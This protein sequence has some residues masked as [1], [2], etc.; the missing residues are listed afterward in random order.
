MACIR[1][2]NHLGPELHRQNLTLAGLTIETDI[3]LT[4]HK[5]YG[6]DNNQKRN[7]TAH[8]KLDNDMALD[9]QSGSKLSLGLDT[10]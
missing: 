9:W 1:D 8:C 2:Q 7:G 4:S 6:D 10:L 3:F 5:S